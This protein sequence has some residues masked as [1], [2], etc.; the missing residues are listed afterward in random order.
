MHKNARLNKPYWI[1]RQRSNICSTPWRLC[2]CACVCSCMR[3][4]NQTGMLRASLM[5]AFGRTYGLPYKDK[6]ATFIAKK[7]VYSIGSIPFVLRGTGIHARSSLFLC[8]TMYGQ[9]FQTVV[10]KLLY[11]C[12]LLYKS[13]CDAHHYHVFSSMGGES[14]HGLS[15][16]LRFQSSLRHTIY[17]HGLWP[18]YCDLR[19]A[20]AHIFSQENNKSHNLLWEPLFFHLSSQCFIRT[21]QRK[22]MTA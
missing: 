17:S 13:G 9:E 21:I 10:L 1:W 3:R 15:I 11:K 14:E 4:R 6:M 2:A 20:R 18:R 22:M 5:F 7:R 19:W 8:F 12:G 16:I